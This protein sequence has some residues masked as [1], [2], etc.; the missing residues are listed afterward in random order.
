MNYNLR[1]NSGILK[2]RLMT[3]LSFQTAK[4]ASHNIFLTSSMCQKLGLI[5][6]FASLQIRDY[7]ENLSPLKRA[8][9][10]EEISPLITFLANND[11][12]SFI[13]GQCIVADGG[14][15]IVPMRVPE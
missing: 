12:A 2:T 9:N 5:T 8:A 6:E 15:S 3:F 1:L 13:T 14:A 10:P 11:M 4:N 7:L